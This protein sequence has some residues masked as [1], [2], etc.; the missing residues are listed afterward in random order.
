MRADLVDLTAASRGGIDQARSPRG[1][2]LGAFRR[3]NVACWRHI[4]IVT[5][6]ETHLG[7][8]DLSCLLQNVVRCEMEASG[9][10]ER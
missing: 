8:V 3:V 6:K 2:E 7:R 9:K 1:N 5:P 4:I 10:K